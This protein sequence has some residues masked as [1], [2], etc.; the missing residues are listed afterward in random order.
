[1][2]NMFKKQY[3]ITQI[4]DTILN[5]DFFV[6]ETKQ[7]PWSS[8]YPALGGT[9]MGFFDTLKAAQDEVE[10]LRNNTIHHYY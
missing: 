10:N 2:T 5:K 3:R 8:W 7:Y 1:M 9:R 4:K 6:V